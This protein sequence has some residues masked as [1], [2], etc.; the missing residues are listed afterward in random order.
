M[1]LANPIPQSPASD[2]NQVLPTFRSSVVARIA[3]MPVA[4]LRIWEQRHQAVR[5]ITAASGHRLYSSADIE[6]ATLLRQLTAQGHAIGLLAALETEHL[7]QMMTVSQRPITADINGAAQPSYLNVVVV[8]QGLALRL[9]RL[10]EQ[11]PAKIAL[12]V[13]A[14]FD[15]LPEAALAAKSPAEPTVDLLLWRAG[16]L[17]RGAHEELRVTKDAWQATAAAVI[18]RFSNSAGRTEFIDAGI[19]IVAEP[20]EDDSLGRWLASL[21]QVQ[22][23]QEKTAAKSALSNAE[24]FAKQT[25]LPPRFDDAALNQFAGLSTE[26]AC[27]C[28]SHLAELLMQVSCFEKYSGDCANRNAAD[29]QLHAYLQEVAGTA[30]MLFEKALERVAIAEGLPLPPRIEL[31]RT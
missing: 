17:Q 27:E 12:R 13:V 2:S 30:R 31:E 6:R 29:A 26:V 7:R 23:L 20:A 10:I 18:Y 11:Q 22:A 8:G 19:E 15:T 4:T 14:V 21:P 1:I 16:S 9:K 3:G 5:P 24:S 25:V 28:P